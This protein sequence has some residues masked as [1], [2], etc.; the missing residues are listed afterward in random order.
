MA[1]CEYAGYIFFRRRP[2]RLCFTYLFRH[3]F[4]EHVRTTERRHERRARR[5]H[6][7][8]LVHVGKEAKDIRTW[9]A[10]DFRTASWDLG[11]TPERAPAKPGLRAGMAHLHSPAH[12]EDAGDGPRPHYGSLPHIYCAY[13]SV[14]E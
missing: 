7:L 10:W 11:N 14:L 4:V 8:V 3:H 1:V 2:A 13:S 12:I 9:L 6:V 5:V